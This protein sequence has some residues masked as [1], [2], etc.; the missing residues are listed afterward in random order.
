MLMVVTDQ[1]RSLI[2]ARETPRIASKCRRRV[3]TC[4]SCCG[5]PAR[6]THNPSPNPTCTVALQTCSR[7]L[8]PEAVA[9]RSG[10][11]KAKT[12][13]DS[14]GGG[15][16]GGGGQ[17]GGGAGREGG[18]GGGG[19]RGNNGKFVITF[20][21]GLCVKYMLKCCWTPLLT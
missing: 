10:A 6:Y 15:G 21:V 9:G 4:Y 13:P 19:Q 12:K 1:R 16:T 2:N 14:N 18:N 20:R 17:D 3:F 5:S 11:K 7:L 8:G